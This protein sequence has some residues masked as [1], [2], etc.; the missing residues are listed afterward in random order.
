[1]NLNE[2]AQY[3]GLGLAALVKS[4]QVTPAELAA[5]FVEAVEGLNPKINAVIEIYRERAAALGDQLE[6]AGPFLGVPFLLKDLGAA[7]AGQTREQGSRL[8]R[9]YVF[10][11]GDS[12]LVQRFKAA[13]LTLLG[14]AATPEFALSSSTESLLTGA[15]RNPW[16]LDLMAGGSSGGA[17]ASVAAG[18]L[19]IAHASD[20]AGS[21]RIPASACG[22]VGLKPS[23]GR[24]THG[25]HG[26]E[27]LGGMGVEFAVSRSVR[28]TA[29]MLDAVSQPAVGDP[30][31]IVQP[32][33]PYLQEM[34]APSGRLRIAFTTAPW[35]PFPIDPEVAEAT[36][37][38]AVRC[39]AMGH[40]V[41]EASPRYDYDQFL[42][43]IGVIWGFGYDAAIDGLAATT[44][45]T[46]GE[47]T[48][49]A[50]T[51]SFYHY[52]KTLTP[53]DWAWAEYVLNQVRRA[54]GQ[55]FRDYDL[56][57]TPTLIQLPEPIGKYSQNATDVD[58]LG[59]FRRC[60]E[61]AVFL[62]LFN[63]T[64]QPAISLP[65]VQSELGLPIGMQFVARF[66]DESTLI[67]LASAFEEAMPWRERIPPVHVSQ[68]SR[69]PGER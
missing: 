67:R 42:K 9:G 60:D 12:F 61:T 17:A 33:R 46:V 10:K 51:L 15:T 36:R 3:D 28:D 53:A 49:E 41:E 19:P 69:S 38:V 45:R 29:A 56:L 40:A 39:E 54:T 31:T 25:P 43:A 64:G 55:F 47:D 1:M 2:Y 68:R 48:L 65:L 23:R 59:F 35:G 57:L 34:G 22:L 26:A 32:E 14:R 58:F 21:I 24:V 66:G 13:G 62:P 52:A 16:N 6:G 4:G 7:E 44:G 20:G 37:Q 18:I 63:A 5:L 50:V 8:L 30:F 27:S 11:K